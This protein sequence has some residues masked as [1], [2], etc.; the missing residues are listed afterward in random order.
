[1]FSMLDATKPLYKVNTFYIV[2][3]RVLK[4]SQR[5]GTYI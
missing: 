4:R 2:N 5:L 3:V 1:M